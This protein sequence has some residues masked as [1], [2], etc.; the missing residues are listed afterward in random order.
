MVSRRWDDVEMQKW[1]AFQR[2]DS[3]VSTTEKSKLDES[4]Y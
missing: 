3:K 1:K 2:K 4:R